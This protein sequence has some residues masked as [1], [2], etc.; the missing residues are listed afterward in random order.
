MEASA[1]DA[2]RSD[3][4]Y[5][6][7]YAKISIHEQML[8]D[9]MRTNA[10]RCAIEGNPGLFHGKVVLDVG[11]GT[12]VLSMFCARAGARR[13]YG[14]DASAIIDSA[15]TIVRANGLHNVVTLVKGKM[16]EVELPGIAPGEVDIIVSEWMGYFL[17]F[18]S[19]LDSVLFA[20]DKW[21]RSEADG[22]LL[23]PSNATLY[24][25]ALEDGFGRDDRVGYWH[26]AWG[27]DMGVLADCARHEPCTH[28]VDPGQIVS[29]AQPVLRLD[30]RRVARGSVLEAFEPFRLTIARHDCLHALAF[31]F[32][33]SFAPAM[34]ALAPAPEY[35]PFTHSQSCE[36]R[37]VVLETGPAS[38]PTHWMQSIFYLKREFTVAPGDIIDGTITCKVNKHDTRALDV[39]FELTLQ[40]EDNITSAS[41]KVH[42]AS[43]EAHVNE[44]EENDDEEEEKAEA[45][46]LRLHEEFCFRTE[47]RY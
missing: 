5:F 7:G 33:C 32:D 40:L 23:L 47:L 37:E 3:P 20:R 44:E 43:S 9:V 45:C 34:T 12:G 22:G 46:M 28:I 24:V 36:A 31:Y 8:K 25:A 30:L 18:E 14:V 38:P 11:C 4:A 41:T 26:R 27:F 13:V 6:G 17:V 1:E 10:Y 42:D 35:E 29:N 2:P 21:L 39:A 19:M 16:E 15:R